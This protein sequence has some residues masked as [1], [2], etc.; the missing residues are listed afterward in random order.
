[1]EANAVEGAKSIRR[2]I[3]SIRGCEEAKKREGLMSS[4]EKV[5][6]IKSGWLFFLVLQKERVFL[7]RKTH[8]KF[9]DLTF[10]HASGFLKL[11]NF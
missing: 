7:L 10:M 5:W 1:M 6:E 3:K 9:K 2:L 11:M 4:E 8:G